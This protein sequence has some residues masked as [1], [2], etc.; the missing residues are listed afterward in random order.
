VISTISRCAVAVPGENGDDL[1]YQRGSVAV[2]PEMLTEMRAP[3]YLLRAA[4]G[5]L[6]HRL[7]DEAHQ[8]QFLGNGDRGGRPARLARRSVSR[9][10]A[11]WKTGTPCAGVDHRL[12]GEAQALFLQAAHRSRWRSGR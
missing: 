12:E 10:S 7:V 5:N 3:G 4:T 11:S 9:R 1:G 8:P 6:H 2:V